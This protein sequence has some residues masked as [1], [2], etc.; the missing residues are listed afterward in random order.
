MLTYS[1]D[2]SMNV[3]LCFLQTS[4]RSRL[5]KILMKKFIEVAA[6]SVLVQSRGKIIVQIVIHCEPHLYGVGSDD[7]KSFM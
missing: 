1:D 4:C 5:V 2:C 6:G 3:T 7:N